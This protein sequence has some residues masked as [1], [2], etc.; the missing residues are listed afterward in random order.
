MTENKH[1][2]C[3]CVPNFLLE[4]EATAAAQ[5]VFFKLSRNPVGVLVFELIERVREQMIRDQA[6]RELFKRDYR[7]EREK[8][9]ERRGHVAEAEGRQCWHLRLR[10]QAEAHWQRADK[11][12]AALDAIHEKQEIRLAT[13]E[14]LAENAK[15]RAVRNRHE[16]R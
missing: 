16:H 11:L 15:Q 14:R 5:E 13:M 2:H 6:Q 3:H 4:P 1:I 8:E 7:S 12:W 10:A 9:L